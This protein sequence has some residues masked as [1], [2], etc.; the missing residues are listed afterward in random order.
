M[1]KKSEKSQRNEERIKK[2]PLKRNKKK[3]VK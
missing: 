3:N 2:M 1:K